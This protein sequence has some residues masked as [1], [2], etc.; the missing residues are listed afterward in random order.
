ME[1]GKQEYFKTQIQFVPSQ[2]D[3]VMEIIRADKIEQLQHLRRLKVESK[4][5]GYEDL[6]LQKC[7]G[8]I[9]EEIAAF[10]TFHKRIKA[11]GFI[12]FC[13]TWCGGPSRDYLQT[14]KH[15]GQTK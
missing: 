5:D 10:D 7:I 1:K 13:F 15:K 12:P 14:G 6:Y 9:K 2:K 11:R 4:K 8:G 3:W